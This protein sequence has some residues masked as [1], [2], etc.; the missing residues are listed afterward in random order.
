MVD[1]DA[2]NATTES[3]LEK[4]RE[5][6][7]VC[8]SCV[9]ANMRV[10]IGRLSDPAVRRKALKALGATLAALPIASSG[11]ER[12][13]LLGQESRKTRTRGAALSATELAKRAYQKSVTRMAYSWWASPRMWTPSATSAS[14]AGRWCAMIL[15]ATSSHGLRRGANGATACSTEWGEGEGARRGAL[16]AGRVRAASVGGHGTSRCACCA[17][18]A[19]P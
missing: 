8:Q 11:C 5:R 2:D 13:H 1:P 18:T 4:L 6:A 9:D 15:V 7:R 10:W 19:C 14:H 17:R 12:K 16:R 3:L